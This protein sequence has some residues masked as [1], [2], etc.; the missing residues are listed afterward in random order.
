VIRLAAMK[1]VVSIC[2]AMQ[3]ATIYGSYFEP[4]LVIKCHS[5]KT[6]RARRGS[7]C[8]YELAADKKEARLVLLLLRNKL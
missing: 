8:M 5:I 6:V 3:P 4:T 1:V 7:A 2:N